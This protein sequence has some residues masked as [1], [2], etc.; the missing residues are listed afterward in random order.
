MKDRL[1]G[2]PRM[3]QQQI[4]A[5]RSTER[6]PPFRLELGHGFIFV[7]LDPDA[8]PLAPTLAKV[9]PFWDGYEKADSIGIPPNGR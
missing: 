6:L 9:E 4:V 2:A 1:I 5:L 7:N 3:D 8:R